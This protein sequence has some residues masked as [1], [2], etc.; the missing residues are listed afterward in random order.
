MISGNTLAGLIINEQADSNIIINN[1][2]GTD[3]TGMQ[4]LGNGSGGIYIDQ[5]AMYNTIGNPTSPNIIAFNSDGGI[6]LRNDNSKFNKISGNSI[7]ENDGLGIDIFP[8]GIVNIN[9]ASDYDN[10]PADMLNSPVI[11]NALYNS[12]N[13]FIQGSVDCPNPSNAV[14]EVFVASPDASGCGQGKRFVGIAI[15]DINGNWTLSTNVLLQTD[16]ITATTIDNT[17]NTS[18][19]SQNSSVIAGINDNFY[20]QINAYPNPCSDYLTITVPEDKQIFSFSVY[21][22]QGKTVKKTVPL[23]NENTIKWN[24]K[25]DNLQRVPSGQY[26]ISLSF[27]DGYSFS[28]LITV[29]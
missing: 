4:S 26:I 24:L 22:I 21:D 6:L 2:I 3:V 10:G 14:I 19:F 17:G 27:G 29:L 25:D 20:S 23:S 1:K 11:S 7:F 5:G 8:F 13:T 9:D 18:E 16:L 15:P 28:K 12:G